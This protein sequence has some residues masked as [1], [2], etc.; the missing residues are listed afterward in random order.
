MPYTDARTIPTLG[1]GPNQPAGSNPSNKDL[2]QLQKWIGL[3][4]K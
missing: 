3:K 2:Q 1:K 4:K